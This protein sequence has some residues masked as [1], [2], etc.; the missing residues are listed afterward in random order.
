[1]AKDKKEPIEFS[2][3]FRKILET[4]GH[5]YT[6]L[7][8]ASGVGKSLIFNWANGVKPRGVENLVALAK[9]LDVSIDELCLGSE[10]GK[11]IFKVMI[12][13]I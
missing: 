2:S 5:T 11:K 8:K 10:Q 1:M 7:S 6:T 3:N 13:E 4:K 12:S 9:V